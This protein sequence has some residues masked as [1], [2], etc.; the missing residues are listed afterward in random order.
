MGLLVPSGSVCSTLR[1]A[2]FSCG[3]H[4][5]ASIHSCPCSIW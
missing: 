3:A 5:P 2:F 4:E 1:V